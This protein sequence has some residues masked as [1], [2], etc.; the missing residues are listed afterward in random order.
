MPNK[1]GTKSR[2]L[3]RRFAPLFF[4][5]LLA[6]RDAAAAEDGDVGVVIAA[7]GY[8]VPV[9]LMQKVHDGGVAVTAFVDKGQKTT[10]SDHGF[11]VLSAPNK[12]LCEP[13]CVIPSN[14]FYLADTFNTSRRIMLGN[15]E[16]K[17][18]TMLNSP[19][20]L[21]MFLDADMMPCRKM[22]SVF[23]DAAGLMEGHDIAWVARVET[24]APVNPN[25]GMMIYKNVPSVRSLL[26]QWLSNYRHR[27]RAFDKMECQASGAWSKPWSDCSLVPQKVLVRDQPALGKAIES[28]AQGISPLI[29]SPYW[30]CKKRISPDLFRDDVLPCCS[31]E[32]CVIDHKCKAGPVVVG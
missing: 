15:R 30:N 9:K 12:S 10:C 18:N 25:S 29:M 31:V 22:S 13:S 11:H 16:G 32:A 17:I 23:A 7:I 20:N 4:F 24:V 6:G 3:L 8:P 27:L 19:Y 14:W 28:M 2:E 1:S 5:L 21:T 26:T